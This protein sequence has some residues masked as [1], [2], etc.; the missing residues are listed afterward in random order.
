MRRISSAKWT[1]VQPVAL[2]P[3][4]I[5]FVSFQIEQFKRMFE[6]LIIEVPFCVSNEICEGMRQKNAV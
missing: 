6:L 5:V 1:G 3:G 2:H 4:V